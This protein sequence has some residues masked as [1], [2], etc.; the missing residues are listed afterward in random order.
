MTS[1]NYILPSTVEHMWKQ[2]NDLDCV[3]KIVQNLNGMFAKSSSTSRQAAI[4]ALMNA[5]MTRES[6][7]GHYLKMTRHI[8]TIEV[9]G[10]KLE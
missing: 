10:A 1:H 6:V 5:R 3:S 8:S 9:I 2:I 4:G 7:W